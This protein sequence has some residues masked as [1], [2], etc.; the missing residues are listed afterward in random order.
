VLKNPDRKVVAYPYYSSAQ[1][2]VVV[3]LLNCDHDLKTDRVV[4]KS[5]LVLR[6]KRPEFPPEENAILLSPDTNKVLSLK[7]TYHDDH[8]EIIIPHLE[9]YSLV[10]LRGKKISQS[11]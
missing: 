10:V 2:T 1:R 11:R 8:V 4:P 5:N 7:T 9:V 3:H 6:I